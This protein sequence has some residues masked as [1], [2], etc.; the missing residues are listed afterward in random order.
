MEPKL[1][2]LAAGAAGHLAHPNQASAVVE[3]A[4]KS[5]IRKHSALTGRLARALKACCPL[6]ITAEVEPWYR[7]GW[8]PDVW[9]IRQLEHLLRRRSSHPC[10]IRRQTI[11]LP[12][13]ACEIA[14]RCRF[15]SAV[16][17]PPVAQ[18]DG[19]GWSMTA[20]SVLMV[21]A[22]VPAFE[23]LEEAA[24][25]A[26]AEQLPKEDQTRRTTISKAS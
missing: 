18:C 15:V 13:D 26:A 25:V 21:E 2:A 19:M 10:L 5:L 7:R 11:H 1:R 6:Q 14:G 16:L 8:M 23:V 17:Q 24:A 3:V 9:P 22:R 4:L 20:L 12:R